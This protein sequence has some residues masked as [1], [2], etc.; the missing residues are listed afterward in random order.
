MQ[1]L[2]DSILNLLNNLLGTSFL[3]KSVITFIVA[4]LPVIELRG[5]IPIGV[6][7][8]GLPRPYAAFVSFCGNMLPIPFVV[9][10]SRRVFSWM[11]KKSHRLGTWADRLESRVKLK[12]KNLYRSELLGLMVFVAIP[13]P[14]T[15]AWT[16][17]LIAALLDI[18]LKAALPAIGAGVILAGILVSGITYGF[19]V[20]I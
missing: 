4:M 12:G 13:L 18:R 7:V 10:F 20:L 9:L 2:T 17:A 14:G 8:L 3:A 15:G 19:A 1:G 5:A 16:G 11:R 6:G